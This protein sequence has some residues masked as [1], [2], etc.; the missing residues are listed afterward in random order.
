[1]PLFNPSG[2]GALTWQALTLGTG[3]T[4]YTTL[5]YGST[6]SV[7]LGSGGIVYFKGL[8]TGTAGPGSVV[9]TLPDA[10]MFPP[11]ARPVVGMNANNGNTGPIVVKADGTITNV[12][13][14][15]AFIQALDGLTY[16]IT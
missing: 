13:Q 1:M 6:P 3:I 7:A 16:S 15:T 5:P 4:A 12:P 11:F 14:W 10:A 9:L 2:G 8:V